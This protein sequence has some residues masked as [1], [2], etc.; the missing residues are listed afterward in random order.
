LLILTKTI[1]KK[2]EKKEK[3]EYILA[4]QEKF[5]NVL[6]VKNTKFIPI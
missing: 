5:P 1:L 2:K 3:D 4:K 6:E